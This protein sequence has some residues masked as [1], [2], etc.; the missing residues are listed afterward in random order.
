[1]PD[2]PRAPRHGRIRLYYAGI[3][4]GVMTFSLMVAGGLAAI[5]YLTGVWPSVVLLAFLTLAGTSLIVGGVISSVISRRVLKPMLRLSEA[6]RRVAQGDFAVRLNYTGHLEEVHATYQSFND[7]VSDL[8]ATETLRNDFIAN[9]SHEFKTPINAIEGYV[10]LLQDPQL[11][12]AER[13][14]YAA[15]TL[16][17]TGRLSALVSNILLLSKLDNGLYANAIQEFPLDE[18]IRQA[19]LLLE[20]RWT[21]KE[22]ELD[23]EL[24]GMRYTGCEAMLM[25]V[26]VNLLENAIKFSANGGT[27]HVRL[28]AL[29]GGGAEV[30]VADEGEGMSAETQRHIFVKFYQGDTSH[31]AEGNGLGLALVQSIVRS[32]GGTTTVESAPGAGATFTV[33]LPA[34]PA[35]PGA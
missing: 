25:Q 35:Q 12:D 30:T 21:Q 8:G 1:M 24:D 19:L 7:M 17:A 15:Q 20:P 5:L 33:R 9:V 3:V 31:R 23:V 4:F 11:S 2:K 18:Q 27:I 13:Q 26:W 22:I 6:S 14:E 16:T 10:T 29:P 32:H 28:R 34:P